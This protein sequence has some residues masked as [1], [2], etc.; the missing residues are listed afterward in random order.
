MSASGEIVTVKVCSVGEL[1]DGRI[2]VFK[3]DGIEG[4]VIHVGDK[5]HACQRYCT[6]EKFPLEFGRLKDAN[7][8]CCTY[9]GAEFDLT[10]GEVKK[11]P[12]VRGIAIYEV[13]IDGDDVLVN[14][15]R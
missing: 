1:P 6:H 9:H 14:V 5:F 2:K 4:V 15:P 3:V 8:L 7:T 13:R 10:T 11:L 12:A